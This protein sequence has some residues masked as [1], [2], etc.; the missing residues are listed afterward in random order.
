VTWLLSSGVA[1]AVAL[2]TASCGDGD[3]AGAAATDG[4]GITVF[5][6]SSL[7][8]AFTELGQVFEEEAAGSS[9]E[10]NF[11]PSSGLAT[12]IIEGAPADVF[13][14]ASAAQMDVV[15]DTGGAEGQPADFATN[16]LEIAVPP[17]NPGRVDGVE[18]F[19]REELVVGLCAEEVPCGQ[20]GREL[21]GKAGVAPAVDT[22]EMEVS[23][24]VTKIE[25]GEVD[26]G[27]V[28]RS[29]VR[30]AA[31]SVDGVEIP[32]DDNVVAT[33][34]IV[35]LADSTEPERARAFVRLVRSERGLRILRRHGFRA[36]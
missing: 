33:Y 10:L 27:I 7:I 36:P 14:S 29:D 28:Y 17:G 34:P 35:A 4:G 20:Y 25:A 22:H 26:A 3:D 32:E 24:L 23:A 8:D 30:S 21:L 16:L 5:A 11:G 19:E 2:A 1:V 18:D 31:G 12:Q 13:A 9:V 15:V 6:A